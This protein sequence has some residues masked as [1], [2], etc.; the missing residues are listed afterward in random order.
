MSYIK[1]IV[2]DSY[3]VVF[4]EP[5]APFVSYRIRGGA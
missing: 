2:R 5:Q 1:E 4:E 3:K